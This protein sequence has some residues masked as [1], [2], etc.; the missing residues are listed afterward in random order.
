MTFD[1]DY[2]FMVEF[3]PDDRMKVNRR[4]LGDR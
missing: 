2:I 1:L 4:M 3:L